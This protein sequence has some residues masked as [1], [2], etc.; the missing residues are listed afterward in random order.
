MKR[1]ILITLLV[2]L[3]P[4][5]GGGLIGYGVGHASSG[6][7]IISAQPLVSENPESAAKTVSDNHADRDSTNET[8]SGGRR[9]AI[10]RSVSIASPAV[11]GINVT[12]L[13]QYR[14]WTP[15]GDDPFFRQFFGDQTV[16][17]QVQG[18]GSG[19]IISADGY[20]LTN[21]HV[22]GNAKE[23]TVTT[24]NGQQYKAELVGTDLISDIALLKIDGK[25]L[26]YVKL[27]N[28]DDV[29]V[30]EW[31]IAMG[32]PFGLFDI[33]DKPTV[34]VGVVSN[35]GVKLQAQEGRVYRGMI[36]TDAA[37]NS[38]NSGG[39]LINAMGEVIGVNAVIYS[40][41]Q[42]SIGLG[43]AIPINRVKTIVNE[44][45][46]SGKIERNFWTGLEIQA[47][48]RRI[49]RYF[50]LDRVE[51]VIVSDVKKNSPGERA[52]FRVGDILL[53]ANG[54]RISDE[55]SVLAVVDEARTGEVITFKVVR[56]HKS[57]ELK[58]SLEKR[59]P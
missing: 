25:N 5:L 48:D 50:G 10:T 6:G 20:I 17:Q 56:E 4:F 41:N 15:W 46:K 26:P 35:T 34:T 7:G 3:V 27:G 22:A 11:V 18:L 1:N 31:V 39:P 12:E 43:F 32:N 47:V 16:T 55:A 42:G 40:P 54:E 23:I 37:I 58:L 57:L 29:I 45:R 38:G 8:V 9:N 53:T 49:A 44:L 28:S 2:L 59:K 14:Q 21:D 52:G 36:Q 30:G 51:G 33:N 13:R 24:T 19:F